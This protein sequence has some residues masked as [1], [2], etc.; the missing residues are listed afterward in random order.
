MSEQRRGVVG[1]K[2]EKREKEEGTGVGKGGEETQRGEARWEGK[3]R[4]EEM[5]E[6]REGERKR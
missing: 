3:G 1:R 6:R 5:E 2:G 4:G